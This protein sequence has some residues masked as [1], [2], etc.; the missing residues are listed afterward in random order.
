MTA[1]GTQWRLVSWP[2]KAKEMSMSGVRLIDAVGLARSA[3][4]LAFQSGLIAYD[5]DGARSRMTLY[6]TVLAR[7]SV[8]TWLAC[9]TGSLAQP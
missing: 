6:R 3:C 1:P 9:S 5:L 8:M 2:R 4:T 7:V